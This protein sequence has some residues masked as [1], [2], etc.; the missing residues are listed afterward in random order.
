[1]TLQPGQSM[2]AREQWTMLPYDGPA[3]RTAHLAFLRQHA[4]SLGLALR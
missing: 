2:Q 4:A 1:M 3:T